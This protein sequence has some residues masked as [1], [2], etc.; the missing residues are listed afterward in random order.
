MAKA[1]IPI[2]DL[3]YRDPYDLSAYDVFAEHAVNGDDEFTFTMR[4]SVDDRERRS[5]LRRDIEAR[6][7]SDQAERLLHLLDISD[8]DVSFLVDCY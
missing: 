2:I 1:V 6:L 4:V 5:A 7:P 3:K 8:W